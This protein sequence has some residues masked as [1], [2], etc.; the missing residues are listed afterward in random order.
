M[1]VCVNEYPRYEILPQYRIVQTAAF[2]DRQVATS[3]GINPT[4]APR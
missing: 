1:P 3:V 2:L 4:I